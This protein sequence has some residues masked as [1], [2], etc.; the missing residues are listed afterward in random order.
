MT[1]SS[2]SSI[3]AWTKL[4]SA[5]LP[6]QLTNTSSFVYSR[7]YSRRYFS[8][9]ARRSG[10]MP[11]TSVYFVMP[12]LS[13]SIAA[14]LM[15]CGVSK[16]GSPAVKLTRS[17]PSARSTCALAARASVTDG[18]IPCVFFPSL[19][20]RDLLKF[21]FQF[22]R[23]ERR[24]EARDVA[25]QAHDFL[26]QARAD[27]K[28][29][30]PGHHEERLDAG[31]E[32]AVHHRHLE[33][34]LEVRD[35]AQPANDDLCAGFF[36]VFNEQPVETL[37][38][39]AVAESFENLADHLQPLV[40]IEE[41]AVLFRVARDRD[42][43]PVEDAKRAL[44][45]VDVTVGDGIERARIDRDFRLRHSL[46]LPP[47]SAAVKRQ[48][49]IAVA[50]PVGQYEGAVFFLE[51]IPHA[52]LRD[53][54]AVLCEH[55]FFRDLL[56]SFP[57][58]APLVRR[59]QQDEIESLAAA[60]ERANGLENRRRHDARARAVA[61][62]LDIFFDDRR[63]RTRD[64]DQN[65]RS[66]AS[67]QRL[68]PEIAG[69]GEKVE[70]APASE[71]VWQD[72]KQRFFHAIRRRAQ[73]APFGRSQAAAPRLSGD[74]AHGG[75]VKGKY[76]LSRILSILIRDVEHDL[77]ELL[78]A[79][80]TL[81]GRGGVLKRKDLIDDR[82]HVRVAEEVYDLT[83]LL[84]AAEGRAEDAQVV[85]E[86]AAQIDG[87]IRA[88]CSAAGHDAAAFRRGREAFVPRFP[89]D[90]VNDDVNAAL[91]GQ[92]ARFFG[93]VV[94]RVVNAVVGAPVIGQREL[95]FA[96]GGDDDVRAH[97]LRYLKRRSGDSSADAE[98]E[99]V[100]AGPEARIRDQHA[101]DGDEHE[102]KGGGLL[103]RESR[104]DGKAVLRRYADVLGVRSVDSLAQDPEMN[105]HEVVI[106]ET[107]LAF[108]AAGRRIE[109]D[110]VAR[111]DVGDFRPGFGDYAGAVA[112]EDMRHCDLHAGE[113]F[114]VPDID[115]VE[116]RGLECDDDVGRRLNLRRLSLF[117][118][119]LIDA[120][121]PVQ[122]YCFHNVCGKPLSVQQPV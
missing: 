81:V 71:I 19:I 75:S 8:T 64:I 66:G 117:V 60:G 63:R 50:P 102:R 115:V 25:P 73:L 103:E 6:P 26:H 56:Q 85:P 30:L 112:A 96:G 42:D 17:T 29:I 58:Q 18:L 82:P 28:M 99:H 41:G 74:Y 92:G 36:C 107:E 86:H 16:S 53:D 69:A 11:R 22:F 90:A 94:L 46:L 38:L 49:R 121:I 79:L 45:Q 14:S 12:F 7:P 31:R 39:D 62:R 98:D 89:A 27:V 1:T 23:N 122:S 95:L 106:R 55:A 44:N 68:E 33:L 65:C 59:V 37:G 109:T 5:C 77:A 76:V 108:A 2:P 13:A 34:V 111:L 70:N 20:K 87:R 52:V 4:E 61:Q 91:L 84:A 80:H 21:L 51:P 100:L 120:A 114:A 43:D 78:A 93:E 72:I 83:E 24:H 32:L 54:H 101:P 3:S 110:G 105:A 9:I 119:Q 88:G 113:A 15:R 57:R 67:A 118:A 116:R 48:R 40:E 10:S 104:R 35:R 47:L 97:L